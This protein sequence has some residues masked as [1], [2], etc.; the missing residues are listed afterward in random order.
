MPRKYRCDTCGE[1]HYPPTGD[2]CTAILE[3]GSKKSDNGSNIHDTV[4]QLTATVAMLADDIREMKSGE[5]PVKPTEDTPELDL[6]GLRRMEPLSSRVDAILTSDTAL[7]GSTTTATADLM[8]L[9]TGGKL[10]KSPRDAPIRKIVKNILWPNQL[11]SRAAGANNGI[12]YDELSLCE[13]VIGVTKIIQLPETSPA[14]SK[15]RLS[16]M[17][18]VM[19]LSRYYNW[20]DVRSMYGTV[21][22]DIQYGSCSWQHS[23]QPYKDTHLNPAALLTKTTTKPGRS[24]TASLQEMPQVCRKFNF[25]TCTRSP[26]QYKHACFTC[27]KYHGEVAMHK[28]K[29]CPQRQ[30]Y[31]SS[32]LTQNSTPNQESQSA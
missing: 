23:I 30:G 31:I 2:K 14:E 18:S 17:E 5:N 24:P 29:D 4:A 8:H 6:S 1:K 22:D 25:E 3:T 27:Q 13:W 11:V 32:R 19:S 9:L 26:C 16:H 28:A 10:L 15:A 20:P 21:L 12:K 7:P